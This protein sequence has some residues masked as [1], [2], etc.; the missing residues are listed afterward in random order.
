MFRVA[1]DVGHARRTGSKGCGYD[2]HEL[3]K[4]VAAE[5]KAA[6]ERFEVTRFEADII[7]F[8][9]L[10]NDADLAETVKAVNAGNYDVSVSL[11]IDHDDSPQPHGAHVCYVS[12]K[13]K[14]LAKE[15]ALRLCPQMPGRAEQVRHRPGLYV[16]RKTKPVAVLVEC[17]FISN[18]GDAQ[19]VYAHPEHVALSIALGIAAW[20]DGEF[21]Q[22]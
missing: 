19:W 8:E 18:E 12:T 4:R 1:I 11:H 22:V 16:L 3:C 17:G 5:L 9:H 21:K 7:D 6:L 13:G 10:S 2:E 14:R 20:V 15:I